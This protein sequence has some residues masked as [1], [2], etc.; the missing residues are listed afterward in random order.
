MSQA[1]L[2]L[3]G[4]IIAKFQE[5]NGAHTHGKLVVTTFQSVIASPIP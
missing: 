5:K 2:C 4:Q 1:F 3:L